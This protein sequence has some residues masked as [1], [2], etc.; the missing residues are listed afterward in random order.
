[1]PEYKKSFAGR[2]IMTLNQIDGKYFSAIAASFNKV[3][4]TLLGATTVQLGAVIYTMTQ[5]IFP[6]QATKKTIICT[7]SK[8]H[9]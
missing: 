3:I 5:A 6:A 8:L 4:M 9:R 7:F 1:M 2:G